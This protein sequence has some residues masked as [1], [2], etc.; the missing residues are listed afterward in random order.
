MQAQSLPQRVPS[1]ILSAVLDCLSKVDLLLLRLVSRFFLH[2]VT[3]LAFSKISIEVN[4]LDRSLF[5][6]NLRLVESLATTSSII[7]SSVR[8]L[9][10]KSLFCARY[11][12][13]SHP[14]GS[15]TT[16]LRDD[17]PGPDEEISK[18]VL[19]EH[20]AP[21]L[22]KFQNLEAFVWAHDPYRDPLSCLSLIADSVSSL[23]KLKDL[24]VRIDLNNV[25]PAKD[26]LPPLH[27]FR[28]LL[29]LSVS[30]EGNRIPAAY[31]EDEIRPAFEASPG[32]ASF[33][34]KTDFGKAPV[35]AI[36]G[37]EPRPKL[38]ELALRGVP[39][40]SE[41]LKLFYSRNLQNLSLS[42]GPSSRGTHIAWPLLWLTLREAGVQLSSLSVAGFE[43]AMDEMFGYLL[44][45]SKLKKL[46]IPII[47]MDQQTAEDAA[48]DIF[49][50]EIVPQHKGSL[51][52]LALRPFYEGAWCYGPAA[53]RA[54]QQCASLQQLTL[55]VCGLDLPRAATRIAQLPE[56]SVGV[57]ELKQVW[58]HPEHCPVLIVSDLTSPLVKLSLHPTYEAG[59]RDTDIGHLN[60]GTRRLGSPYV[61]EMHKRLDEI[62]NMTETVFLR[63]RASSAGAR[64]WP[65]AVRI[66]YTELLKEKEKTESGEE[67]W[68]YHQDPIQRLFL[69]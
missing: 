53:S 16:I 8:T 3:P 52:E 2:L 27:N 38:V 7:S 30:S 67:I 19:S 14:N 9:H 23:P 4:V 33:S 31:C 49:W 41:G 6:R 47:Q 59:E 56:S 26:Q 60:H 39:L 61:Y 45:Y 36:L 42:T 5:H 40:P 44:S 54:I 34:L 21:F 48:G 22:S 10:I 46:S 37:K 62:E 1:E 15:Q 25:D 57:S 43:G 12:I 13:T 24:S 51:I 63:M 58:G 28:N 55:G 69:F 29:A 17:R 66:G 50:R 64:N 65:A 68:E 18:A 11:Q 35:Q 20:L 32:L